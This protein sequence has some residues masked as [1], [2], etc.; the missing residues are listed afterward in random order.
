LIAYTTENAMHGAKTHILRPRVV[1]YALLLLTIM[2]IFAYSLGH[3]TTLGLDVIRD[4]N[5][6]YRET[7]DGEIENVY[8][9]KILNMDN[10]G[11]AYSLH[12]E[13]IHDLELH[14][15]TR[16]IWVDAGEV[17]ELPVRL[18]VEEDELHQRS[19]T[20]TFTLLATDNPGL[21]V[22]KEARFLGP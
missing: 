3:R 21:A 1:I 12:V 15:D 22:R 2:S 11:H 5:R 13:G 17:L 9:L 19:S 8:I 14:T 7:D 6:L 4:R 10:K 20:V 18:S 16:R